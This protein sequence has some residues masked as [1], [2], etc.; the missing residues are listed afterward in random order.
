MKKL[1][2]K[3]ILA[4]DP[5]KRNACKIFHSSAKLTVSD[6]NTNEAFKS[7]HQRNMTKIKDHACK[8]W[9]VLDVIIKHSIKIFIVFFV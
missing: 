5:E 1:K 8:N 3:A 2:V 9:I 4:L 7:T 6:S